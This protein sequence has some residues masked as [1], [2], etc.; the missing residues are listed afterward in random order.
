MRVCG[1]TELLVIVVVVEVEE[2]LELELENFI[3][4]RL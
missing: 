2:E 4:Q 3:L 1:L